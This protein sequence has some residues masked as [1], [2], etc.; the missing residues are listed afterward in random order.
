MKNKIRNSIKSSA[1]GDYI[2]LI[3]FLFLLLSQNFF[4][5]SLAIISIELIIISLNSSF[6]ITV[7]TYPNMKTSIARFYKN[8]QLIFIIFVIVCFLI[9]LEL[10]SSFYSFFL[11]S[12]F[13]N[14]LR[15][16]LLPHKI[17]FYKLDKLKQLLM[18][19]SSFFLFFIYFYLFQTSLNIFLLIPLT[20]SIR[21]ISYF[22]FVKLKFYD[23]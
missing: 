1:E 4:L 19:E 8:N 6:K 16:V 15:V 5:I 3:A 21:N 20:L 14:I 7:A 18:V 9:N 22:I 12:F 2:Y 13:A 17:Y 23:Q 10:F 11:I